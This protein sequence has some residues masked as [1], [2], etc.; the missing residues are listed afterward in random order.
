M[1]CIG[2]NLLSCAVFIIDKFLKEIKCR[3]VEYPIHCCHTADTI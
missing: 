1:S 2:E 3:F